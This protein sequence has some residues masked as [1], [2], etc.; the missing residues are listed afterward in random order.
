[1]RRLAVWRRRWIAVLFEFDQVFGIRLRVVVRDENGRIS[2]VVDRRIVV[3]V[4]GRVA[5][6]GRERV[7]DA[8][9]PRADD[10][11]HGEDRLKALCVRRAV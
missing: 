1:M 4:R 6:V 8:L 10:D 9:G 5:H 2:D 7:F 3:R 11:A